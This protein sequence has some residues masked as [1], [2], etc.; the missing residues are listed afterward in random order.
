MWYTW[1][2]ENACTFAN[3]CLTLLGKIKKQWHEK[4]E[5]EG[6]KKKYDLI[7]KYD[8]IK[9]YDLIQNNTL[10]NFCGDAC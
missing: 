5:A 7:Q 4:F 1:N 3:E 2:V 6:F 9:K 8:L 10:P